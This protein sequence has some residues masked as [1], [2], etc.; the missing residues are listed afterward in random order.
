MPVIAMTR[1]MGSRGKDLAIRL[2]DEL[3]LTIVH[4]ELVEH[5][6]AE[7]MHISDSTVHRFLETK[8]NILD[9][10]GVILDRTGLA[11]HTAEE[12]YELAEQG[13]VII[14]GLGRRATLTDREPRALRPCLRATAGKSQDSDEAAMKPSG[15]RL[16]IRLVRVRSKKYMRCPKDSAERDSIYCFPFLDVAHPWF[17]ME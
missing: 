11:L 7:K 12:I 13:N 17:A 14:R 9:R 15:A 2:A 6:V 3:G 16:A 5:H 1:E 10:L 4:H 8:S